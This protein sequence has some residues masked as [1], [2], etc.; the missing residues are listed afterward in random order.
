MKNR[1]KY[2]TIPIMFLAVF[3]CARLALAATMYINLV[4]VNASSDESRELPLKYYLPKELK[5]DDILDTAGLLVDYDIDQGTYFIHGTLKMQP[6]ESRTIRVE[7]KDVWNIS[8]EEIDLL[9]KE[10]DENLAR[11]QGTEYYER[12]QALREEMLKKLDY[13]IAQQEN[14]AGNV[15]RRIEEYRAHV[16][17]LNEIRN[18]TFSVE[19]WE[20]QQAKGP[21]VPSSYDGKTVKF[22]IEVENPNKEAEKTLKQQ[23]YLP[24]EVK[25][26][27]IVD[28]QGF[29]VRYDEGKEQS[30]LYKEEAFKAGEKK[31]YEI[32]IQDI[33]HVPEDRMNGFSERAKSAM[34]ELEKSDYATSAQYLFDQI[35]QNLGEVQKLQEQPQNMK[36]HVGIF[37]I[38]KKTMEVVEDDLKKLERILALVRQKR[39]EELEKSRV[40][41]VL[42]QLKSLDGVTA[43]SQ[44][45]FGQ[46]LAVDKTW[47]IIIATLIFVGIFTALHFLV[48]QKRSRDSKRKET[49]QKLQT[50]T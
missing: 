2:W 43:I 31:R 8:K 7:V 11:I 27:H 39:L 4:A 16:D 45:V 5:P 29:E 38:N 24:F 10:I 48:W 1:C 41:N 6:K 47:R 3:F 19:Y 42:K 32:F 18:T 13:V 37:R 22:V 49:P 50:A 44:A 36:E 40:K 20:S 9:K 14:F 15:E 12:G 23:H 46:K 33:W 25:S 28:P 34:T 26:E 17:V 35:T 21:K 30:Y